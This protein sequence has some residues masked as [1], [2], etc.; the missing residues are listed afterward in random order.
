[1]FLDGKSN[2]NTFDYFYNSI[3]KASKKPNI[4]LCIL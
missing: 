2:D 1:M 3:N 4:L